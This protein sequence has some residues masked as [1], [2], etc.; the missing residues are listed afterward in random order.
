MKSRQ[1]R[2]EILCTSMRRLM[3]MLGL[4]AA[5][6]VPA[7]VLY[8][9]TG[10]GTLVVKKG[11]APVGVPVVQMTITGSV[12]G[13]VDYGR[14]VI[15]SGVSSDPPS[16]AGYEF[17]GNSKVS[18]TA[19]YWRGSELKFR[20]VEGK[21]TILVY[22]TGVNL[23]AVGKGTVKLAGLPGTTDGDGS[24]SLNGD[25]EFVSLPATQTDMLYIRASG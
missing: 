19:Q 5:F 23:V 21:Y 8:A 1:R 15:D 14:I 7:G 20:A 6:A 9:A 3:I 22:G 10:D 18:E 24:Y 4:L 2:T 16:V 17:R 13:S 12:I 25:K 11:A